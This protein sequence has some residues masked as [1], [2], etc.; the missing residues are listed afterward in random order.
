LS[1]DS[2]D[3]VRRSLPARL[4]RA[5]WRSEGGDPWVRAKGD[6]RVRIRLEADAVT[7]GALLRVEY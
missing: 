1:A 3:V 7:G 4:E 5:G 2:L 6:R